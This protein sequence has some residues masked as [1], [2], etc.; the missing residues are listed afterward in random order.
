MKK[1]LFLAFS[2]LLAGPCLLNAQSTANPS[3]Q[4][5]SVT[6]TSKMQSPTARPAKHATAYQG[7]KA[8]ATKPV[9]NAQNQPTTTSNQ[10]KQSAAT[11]AG[12]RHLAEKQTAD[13]SKADGRHSK[14]QHNPSMLKTEGTNSAG[15]AASK[16]SQPA[17]PKTN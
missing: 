17:S 4:P 5:G 6:S 10:T 13:H 12:K 3:Q 11:S 14:K 15:N 16:S 7:A 8:T 1:V 2:V 9:S